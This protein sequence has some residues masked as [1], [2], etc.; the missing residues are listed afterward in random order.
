MENPVVTGAGKGERAV[1]RALPVADDLQGK[2]F[3]L[4]TVEGPRGKPFGLLL[5][6]NTLRV[7]E[8]S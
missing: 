3:G 7:K 5:P 6:Q 1:F 4:L 8:E 2:P